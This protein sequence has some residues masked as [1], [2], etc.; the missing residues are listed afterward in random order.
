VLV[1]FIGLANLVVDLYARGVVR[2]A[3]DEGA[4]A[5]AVVDAGPGECEQRA[6]DV[7]HTLLGGPMG[8]AVRVECREDGSRMTAVADVE[9]PSWLPVLLPGWAFGIV[10]SA[11]RERSP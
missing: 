8:R 7:V 3:V 2:A 4:R 10:G 5:G 6:H 9:L 11:T 1:V